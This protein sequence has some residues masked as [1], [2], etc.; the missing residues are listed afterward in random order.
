AGGWAAN[1]HEL[2]DDAAQPRG[3]RLDRL[4]L[5]EQHQHAP[6]DRAGA[7]LVDGG[8]GEALLDRARDDD[9]ATQPRDRAPHPSRQ[10]RD[11][12][13]LIA[14][15]SQYNAPGASPAGDTTESHDCTRTGLGLK[16]PNLSLTSRV[17]G[18]QEESLAKFVR[19]CRE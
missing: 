1:G 8:V 6:G 16:L 18:W 10:D 7:H 11:G 13:D 2:A 5:V 15:F 14:S 12:D 19:R 17:R 4:S 9:A 3:H